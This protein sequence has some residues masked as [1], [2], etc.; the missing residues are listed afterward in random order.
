MIGDESD[1]VYFRRRAF[2]ETTVAD[3]TKDAR[4]SGI[5]RELA[6]LYEA[7]AA[8]QEQLAANIEP[9]DRTA[10]TL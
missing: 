4:I 2:A 10:A 5:H 6:R 3:A 9:D 7:R 8:V 1:E